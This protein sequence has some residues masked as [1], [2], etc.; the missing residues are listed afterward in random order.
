MCQEAICLVKEGSRRGLSV[1]KA[2][3]MYEMLQ[4]TRCDIGKEDRSGSKKSARATISA[5]VF[6]DSLSLSVESGDGGRNARR[7]SMGLLRC[8]RW[9]GLIFA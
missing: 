7:G 5:L 6:S 4:S 9:W 1:S 3:S 2:R 8:R